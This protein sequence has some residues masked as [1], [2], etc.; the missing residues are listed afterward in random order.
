MG[1]DAGEDA[2]SDASSDGNMTAI[3][4][5]NVPAHVLSDFS[6]AVMEPVLLRDFV[7]VGELVE[8]GSA[9]SGRVERGP[10]LTMGVVIWRSGH[11]HAL[12]WAFF[13]Y[14]YVA[15]RTTAIPLMRAGAMFG[16][17]SATGTAW[18]S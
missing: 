18:T 7:C 12:R 13:Q 8:R 3:R 2:E 6:R 14:E 5:W 15:P 1:D 4:I 9:S 10:N 11:A 16:R 17:L